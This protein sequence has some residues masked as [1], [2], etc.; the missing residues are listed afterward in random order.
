MSLISNL[1]SD[2]AVSTEQLA[3]IV[4]LPA[5]GVARWGVGGVPPLHHSD[6][7]PLEDLLDL[8]HQRTP[9]PVRRAVRIGLPA[10]QG[11][12]ILAA[13][14]ETGPVFVHERLRAAP[15]VEPLWSGR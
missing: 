4:G 7:R 14:E 15:R 10:L 13:L 12:S 11:R 1:C 5:D 8:L 6:F 2:L 9:V 3:R